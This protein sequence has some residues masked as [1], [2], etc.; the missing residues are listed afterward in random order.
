MSF[1]FHAKCNENII[2]FYSQSVH[3]CHTVTTCE[4]SLC[5]NN[6]L[7]TLEFLQCSNIY[8]IIKQYL[9]ISFVLPL[10]SHGTGAIFPIIRKLTHQVCN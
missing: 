6:S 4:F 2:H 1:P 5:C 8:Y 9:L 3:N 7:L 10:L